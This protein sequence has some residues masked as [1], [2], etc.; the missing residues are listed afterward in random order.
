M[1]YDYSKLIGRIIEMF[2]TRTAFAD[3]MHMSESTLSMKLN[4]KST[5]DQS[6]MMEAS[7]LLEF[8]PK[9]I[10]VYFFTLKVQ[11]A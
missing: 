3:K 2:G 8:P 9:D 5:W 7:R 1:M 11:N 6:E 10:Q 4:N